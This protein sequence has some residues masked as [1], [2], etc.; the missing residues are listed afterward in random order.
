MALVGLASAAFL[1][2]GRS[3]VPIL[4][5]DRAVDA[6]VARNL[7]ARGGAEAWQE[8]SSLRLTGL[9]DVGRGMQVPYVLEQKRPG[10]M[11]LEF[12]F[13]DET[14]TQCTDGDS[15]WK[16]APFRGR[17]TPEPMT[18]DELREIAGSAD[19]YG[20]LF[21]YAS[22]GHEVQILGREVVE[23]RNAFKLKVTLPGGG[24]RWVYL[25]AETGLEIKLEAM[26][27]LAGHERRV[28][29]FYRDWQAEGGLLIP[30]RQET[31]AE[32]QSESHS[33]SVQTV[34]VNPP[35]DDARF[36]MPVANRDGAGPGA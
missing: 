30:R 36:A 2:L 18:D 26:R 29:T 11:C 24:V 13:D 27:K 7:A 34:E 28:E 10:K 32:G 8:V 16:I 22:R 33:L 14:A 3:D 5:R 25:D 1:L 17:T 12:V 6:L 23:G 20:L 35:L 9:M 4:G 31:R 19:P 15:G 21:D